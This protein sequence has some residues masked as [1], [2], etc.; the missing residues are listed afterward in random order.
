MNNSLFKTDD[1]R[2]VKLK[3]AIFEIRS[4]KRAI[5]FMMEE[6]VHLKNRVA[7]ILKN[8]FSKKMLVTLEVFQSRFISE[9]QLI[10]LLRNELAQIEQSLHHEAFSGGESFTALCD[11]LKQLHK[12]MVA[13]E[14]QFIKLNADFND[15]LL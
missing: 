6:N 7:E 9:D 10:G 8:G 12:S 15:F 3:Q 4:L 14:N 13:T 5:D 1:S 11:K 2:E